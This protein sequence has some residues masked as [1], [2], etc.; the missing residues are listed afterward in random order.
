MLDSK[1]KV[2]SSIL[3][4]LNTTMRDAQNSYKISGGIHAAAL[5]NESGK[6]ITLQEDIGRHNAIDKVIGYCLL[7]NLPLKDHILIATGR[8]S[9]EMVTKSIIAEIPIV[10]S[11]SAAT[12]LAAD[13]A[14]KYNVTL[15]GYIRSNRMII[16]THHSRIMIE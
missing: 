7:R 10:I 1:L 2:P 8:A 12:A 15:I 11:V 5:F 3:L 4:R 16:Y 14:Q 9:H 6:L 13:I